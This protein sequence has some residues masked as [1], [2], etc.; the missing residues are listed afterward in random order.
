VDGFRP[1]NVYEQWK[2]K[3]YIGA[4]SKQSFE[5]ISRVGKV[6]SSFCLISSFVLTITDSQVRRLLPSILFAGAVTYASYLFALTWTP[7]DRDARLMSSQ[8]M[9]HATM[10]GIVG[11]NL[12]IL[13]L[14]RFPPA[15][16]ILNRYFIVT[17]GIVRPLAHLGS[18]FSHQGLRHLAGNMILLFFI[19]TTLHE[20]MGR[21]DFLALYIS[22]GVLGS[23]VSLI[24]MVSRGILI[25]SSLGASGAVSG[26]FAAFCTINPE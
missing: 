2:L 9:S 17:P 26:I 5:E 18:T 16:R 6:C 20:Q 15:W 21:G 10:F 13:V 11:I 22:S 23:V 19:G 14:W 1:P 8:T 24:S 12:G 4:T 25:S 7:P 3:H